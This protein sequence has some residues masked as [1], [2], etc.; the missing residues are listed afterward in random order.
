MEIQERWYQEDS[1]EALMEDVESDQNCHPIVVAPTGT[2]KTHIIAKLVDKFINKYP[3]SDVLV[4]CDEANVLEQDYNTLCDY[5]S[6]AI[7]GLYSAS[8]DSRETSKITVA[9]IQSVHRQPDKFQNC[10]LVIIDECHTVN[11]SDKGMYRKFLKE[12]DANYV[13][14]TATHFRTGH[15]YIVEGKGSL[16]N[17]I[18]YDM[19]SPEI[20]KRLQ[21]EGWISKIYSKGTY[22]ELNAEKEGVRT[23][24]GDYKNKD[25][26]DKFDRDEITKACCDE[27]IEFAKESNRKRWLVFAI[28]IKHAD[29]IRNYLISKGVKAE[30]VHSKKPN[31]NKIIKDYK[32]GKYQVLIN[33]NILVKGFDVKDIDLIVV[34]RPSKSPVIHVQ[35]IGRGTRVVYADGFNLDTINGRL[36][37]IKASTKHECIVM[38]FP[39]NTGLLGPIDNVQIKKK[40]DKKGKGTQIMKN[41]PECMMKNYGVSRICF[42]CGHEFI[43]KTNLDIFANSADVTTIDIIDRDDLIYKKWVSVNEVKYAAIYRKGVVTS[44]KV[45]YCTEDMDFTEIVKPDAKKYKG[46]QAE[47]WIRTRWDFSSIVI[48]PNTAKE[49]WIAR[50]I[51]KKPTEIYVDVHKKFKNIV[52]YKFPIKPGNA[53]IPSNAPPRLTAPKTL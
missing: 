49:L 23:Q 5:F 21:D 40:G 31:R 11:T 26:S 19:S 18:S 47:Y 29:N 24:G 41:C 25:L 17:K 9:G 3:E 32:D 2:G 35:M 44:I 10:L 48:I 28:D 13:G 39:D 50:N 37:A 52:D 20:F 34:M 22:Q 27:A 7:V 53:P 42:N 43:F 45:V 46:R 30:S 38:D 33:V 14:L 1:A 6:D 36:S 15:G 16:F 12:I 8:L 51:L 4:L